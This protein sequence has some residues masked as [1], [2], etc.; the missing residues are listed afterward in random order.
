MRRL[1]PAAHTG[2]ETAAFAGLRRQTQAWPL[3]GTAPVTVGLLMNR[4]DP[5]RSE[6]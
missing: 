3:P 1:M 4:F 5:L 6:K 2:F